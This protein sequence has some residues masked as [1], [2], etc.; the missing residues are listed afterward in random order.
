VDTPIPRKIQYAHLRKYIYE[1]YYTRIAEIKKEGMVNIKAQTETITELLLYL[2]IGF[3]SVNS[4]LTK[5]EATNKIK[6][7]ILNFITT[8]FK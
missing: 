4:S 3:I 8:Y 6:K 2:F 1:F 7:T 5:E